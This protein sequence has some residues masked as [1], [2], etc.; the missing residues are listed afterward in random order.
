[1]TGRNRSRRTP[2]N[3]STSLLATLITVVAMSLSQFGC[4][5]YSSGYGGVAVVGPTY[6]GLAYGAAPWGG[7]YGG[8]YSTGGWGGNY[9]YYHNGYGGSGP[10]RH[11]SRK[12]PPNS[13]GA[14][15][16]RKSHG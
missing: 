15:F 16:R 14:D 9:G 8:A 10:R 13:G 6:G 12:T 2:M 4:S 11:R 3:R 5:D 1:M 7:Y